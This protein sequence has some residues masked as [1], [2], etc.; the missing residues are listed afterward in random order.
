[1]RFCLGACRALGGSVL[2]RL[3]DHDRGRC[4]LA[5]EDGVFRDPAWLG[6]EPDIGPVEGSRESSPWRQGDCSERYEQELKRLAAAHHVYA[7][8]CSRREIAED[9]PVPEGAEVPYP[10]RCRL[11]GL[12]FEPG[13]G[14][15]VVLAAGE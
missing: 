14:V 2:L 12:S 9:N 1:M 4:R 6:L 7:C 13:R 3:E 10:G 15:R 5:Y 11:R 8:D